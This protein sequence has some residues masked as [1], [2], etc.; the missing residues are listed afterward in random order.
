MSIHD[1]PAP[2]DFSGGNLDN[3][4]IIGCTN[5]VQSAGYNFNLTSG[6]YVAGNP[7]VVSGG[8]DP[9]ELMTGGPLDIINQ[10][11]GGSKRKRKKRSRKLKRSNKSRLNSKS[12]K[13]RSKS[14]RKSK[15]VRK[16]LSKRRVSLKRKS[17]KKR[18]KKSL[19]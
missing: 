2:V 15:K 3:D 4:N 17:N 13:S 7:E 5:A 19:K 12:K 6:G 14:V 18:S 11:G 8:T 1:N 10:G 9:T 16:T